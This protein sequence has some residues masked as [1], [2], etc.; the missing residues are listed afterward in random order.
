MKLAVVLNEAAGTLL[1][2]PVDQAVRDVRDWFE[3][4]GAEVEVSSAAGPACVPALRRAAE[5]DVDVVVVGGG[6]GTIN[7]AAGMLVGTG[8]ALGVLPLGTMNLLAKDLGITLPLEDAVAALARGTIHA[9]DVGEVNGHV[10][11]NNSVLGLYPAMVQERERQRGVHGLRKWPAMT[12]AAIK[13]LW[14]FPRLTVTVDT[15]SGPRLIN[16]PVLAVAN[17]AYDDGFGQ[18]LQRSRLDAGE[19]A[20]YVA[21]HRNALGLLR[22]M[23]DVALGTWQRNPDLEAYTVTELTVASRRRRLKVANDGEVL[24]LTP[25]LRYRVRAKALNVLLPAPAPSAEAVA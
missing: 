2:E 21:R 12:V 23:A 10:F 1:G 22:L 8:K 20:V 4:A 18:F 7:T 6:D 16:T 5:S 11:L 15:G 24:R 3:R 17:N 19:L 25:P 9:I 13:S 14:A